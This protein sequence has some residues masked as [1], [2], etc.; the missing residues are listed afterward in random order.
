MSMEILPFFCPPYKHCSNKDI[1]VETAMKAV[2]LASFHRN[3][4]QI[5]HQEAGDH[6]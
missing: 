3:R 1:K 2:T 6:A 4:S 5:L